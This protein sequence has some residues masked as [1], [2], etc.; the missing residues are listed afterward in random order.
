MRADSAASR[1][2]T[3]QVQEQR[4]RRRGRVQQQHIMA[5]LAVPASALALAVLDECMHNH[6]RTVFV[7]THRADACV[8][9]C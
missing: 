1:S 9:V 8:H 2:H 5:L 3:W 6:H 7:P 4:E